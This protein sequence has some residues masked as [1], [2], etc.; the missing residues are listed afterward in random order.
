MTFAFWGGLRGKNDLFINMFSFFIYLI[1]TKNNRF[2]RYVFKKE[3]GLI[4]FG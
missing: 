3:N 4:L 1:L 2:K